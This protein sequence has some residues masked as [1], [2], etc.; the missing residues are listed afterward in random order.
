MVGGWKPWSMSRFATSIVV[1][2]FAFWSLS[3]KTTSWSES[4]S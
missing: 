3:S 2:P 4:V 1:T